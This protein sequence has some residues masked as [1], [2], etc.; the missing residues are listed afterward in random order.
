MNP[1]PEY[2]L[3][4]EH[5]ELVLDGLGEVWGR[6]PV[7][8]EVQ[9]VGHEWAPVSRVRFEGAPRTVI[10]KTT[11]VDGEGHGG[12]AYLRREI[13][14]L[15]MAARSRVAAQVLWADHDA[16]IVVQSDLGSWPTLEE[17]LLGDDPERAAAA[18]IGYAETIS[19]LH[20]S[21]LGCRAEYESELARF[22]SADVSTDAGSAIRA[23][24]RWDVV[25]QACA[26][27][28]LPDA[29]VARDDIAFVCSRLDEPGA[30]GALVHLDLNPT[31]ALVTDDGVRLVDFEG[32]GFGHIGFDA[33]FLHYPFPH[34]SPNWSVLPDHVVQA[35]DRAYRE[36]LPAQVFQGY[37]EMLAIGAAVALASRVIRLPVIART[38]QTAYDSW[39]RRAQLVQQI[40]V[41]TRLTTQA[42]VLPALTQ[43]TTALATAI[44]NRWA[45]A[46]T[47]PP[48]VYA[49]FRTERTHS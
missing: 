14:G 48:R 6:R 18:M 13:A 44:S 22:G 10:V 15:R 36:A 21:T 17:V 5:L 31:N 43:W 37:D 4:P 1:V 46:T 42:R 27:L 39:R 32:A 41:F 3:T 35:A 29:A 49:A 25:E 40:S 47:P 24:R 38:D 2:P 45:D 26:D 19:R 20:V 33:S 7:V 30:Y 8:A 16:G 12:P 23:V 11:R 9:A 34:H 28:G